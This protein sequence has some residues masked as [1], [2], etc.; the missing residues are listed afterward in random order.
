[1]MTNTCFNPGD[2]TLDEMIEDTK[3]GFLLKGRKMGQADSNSEFMF[4]VGEGLEIKNGEICG[5]I[6]QLTISGLAID[7]LNADLQGISK[8]VVTGYAGFCGKNQIAFTGGGGP[9]VK[10]KVT[11]GGQSR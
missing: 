7:V 2:I 11:F 1:R 9:Y 4:G 5:S 6:K 8:N 10:T 3:E